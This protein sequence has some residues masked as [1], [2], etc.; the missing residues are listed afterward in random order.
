MCV[1]RVSEW[2]RA[3]VRCVCACASEWLISQC[4]WSNLLALLHPL[5]MRIDW[6][7]ISNIKYNLILPVIRC[8]QGLT[9]R[10]EELLRVIQPV[11]P[12]GLVLGEWC[13][14]APAWLAGFPS[15][16]FNAHFVHQ[17]SGG[18]KN[19]ICKKKISA[20][21][22]CVRISCDPHGCYLLS[23]KENRGRPHLTSIQWCESTHTGSN[24]S[25]WISVSHPSPAGGGNV[26]TLISNHKKKNNLNDTNSVTRVS[27]LLCL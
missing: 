13:L 7:N 2:V 18:K 22:W 20:S 10:L 8:F 23:W 25:G 11:W 1:A 19:L 24:T 14:A 17:N 27:C 15:P 26:P 9:V 5:C 3:R 6:P 21:A 12:E 16:F 4:C